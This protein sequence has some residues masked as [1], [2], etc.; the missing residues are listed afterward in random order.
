TVME[1][2]KAIRSGRY[3]H[4]SLRRMSAPVATVSPRSTGSRTSLVSLLVAKLRVGRFVQETTLELIFEADRCCRRAP[5]DDQ[6][7]FMP[8]FVAVAADLDASGN[9]CTPRSPSMAPGLC[10]PCSTFQS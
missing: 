4:V 5:I 6:C 7:E 9:G 3:L 1:D 8:G 2:R 10:F